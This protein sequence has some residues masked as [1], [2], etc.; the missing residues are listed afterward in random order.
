MLRALTRLKRLGA[1]VAVD[2]FGTGYSSLPPPPGGRPE[3]TAAACDQT[4][5]NCG[6]LIG[7]SHN[8]AK[9]AGHGTSAVSQY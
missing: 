3:G 2:D 5:A 4:A 6:I 9:V 7:A 1:D 8:R